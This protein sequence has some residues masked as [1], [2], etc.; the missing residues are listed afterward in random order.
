VNRELIEKYAAGADV[1]A[2]AIE[3]L[4]REQLLA[5][6]VPGTWSIQQIILHLMDSDLI[7]ADR[8]KRVAAEDH[9]TLIGYN[10]TAFAKN[11]AYEEVSAQDAAEIFRLNRRMTAELLRRLPDTAFKRTG[12]HNERGEVTLE[13][14]VDTYTGHLDHHVKFLKEKRKLLGKPL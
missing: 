14:L 5:F 7:A 8:M 11:L 12:L 4:S 3:G 10:E 9:P 1:P 13:Q 2:R 6:P